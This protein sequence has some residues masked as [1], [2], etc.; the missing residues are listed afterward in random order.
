M[1]KLTP[2][3]L[4]AQL[5]DV[6][7]PDWDGEIA[8]YRELI[9]NSPLKEKGLLEIA[10]GTGR[11]TM[12]LAR[13][14]VDITGLDISPEF[15]EIARLK[16]S[17]LSNVSWV[18][19]DMRAFKL[20]RKFGFVI[21]PGHSFQFMLTPEDQ[22]QCLETIRRHM[23]PAGTLVIHLDHQDPRWHAA[24]LEQKELVYQ[25]GPTLTHPITG[26]KFR[27]SHAWSM[28]PA[29]QTATVYMDWEELDDAGQVIEVWKLEPRQ[30]HCAFRFEMEHLLGRTGFCVEAV[31]GDFFGG[32]LADQSDNMIWVA[33][34]PAA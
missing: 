10:C 5:Y 22:V 7:V 6:R 31:Y 26:R 9:L 21:S 20:G 34:N 3:E 14:G 24:L 17:G 18:P 25:K 2:N 12:Q 8:F 4:H 28:E 16:S 30:L 19:G 15:L 23:V 1:S 13:E 33:R 11:V 29:T 32:A 27:S